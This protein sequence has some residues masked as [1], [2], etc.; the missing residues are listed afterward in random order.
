MPQQSK[1]LNSPFKAALLDTGW[2]SREQIGKLASD[3]PGSDSEGGSVGLSVYLTA[4]I[5]SGSVKSASHTAELLKR[6]HGPFKRKQGAILRILVI[7]ALMYSHLAEL[8]WQRKLKVHSEAAIRLIGKSID[9]K[10][11]YPLLEKTFG[12]TLD[13]LSFQ[14]PRSNLLSLIMGRSAK[15]YLVERYNEMYPVFLEIVRMGL[16]L[17]RV[18][19]AASRDGT[20]SLPRLLLGFVAS[21]FQVS[22]YDS[23]YD[24]GDDCTVDCLDN[25]F[26][27]VEEDYQ[28]IHG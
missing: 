24:I 19:F 12:D 21:S 20:A 4:S 10:L 26:D 18:D 14:A 1:D 23:S 6:S 22:A 7:Q 8:K 15:S 2:L 25:L 9:G 5:A 13:S 3:A 28:R 11:P 16:N 17:R 27:I